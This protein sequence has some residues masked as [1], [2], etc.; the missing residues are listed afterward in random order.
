MVQTR[1]WRPTVADSH[2]EA[3]IVFDCADR[4]RYEVGSSSRSRVSDASS[5][6]G[7]T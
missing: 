1:D 2:G 5:S 4:Y 3:P 7:S 6:P